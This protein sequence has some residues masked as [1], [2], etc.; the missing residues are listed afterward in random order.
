MIRFPKLA[1]IVAGLFVLLSSVELFGQ[2]GTTSVHGT[3]VDNS[4][5]AVVAAKVIVQNAGQR[6]EREM[7][8]NGSGEYK[9]LA[10]PPGT[11]TITV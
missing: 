2:T 3:V 5:A 7:H 8:T 1:L 6:L 11:Y 10:L 4:G 9:F